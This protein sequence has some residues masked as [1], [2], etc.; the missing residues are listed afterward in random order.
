MGEQA[1]AQGAGG[2]GAQA[3]EQVGAA[4]PAEQV[5]GDDRLAHGDGDDVPDQ[6]RDPVD[7]QQGAGDQRAAGG[8][9]A[10]RGDGDEGDGQADGAGGAEPGGEGF[11]EQAAG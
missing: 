5:V 9:Q 3:D 7:G 4:D 8:G 11:G 1:G 6:D 2:L 10:G